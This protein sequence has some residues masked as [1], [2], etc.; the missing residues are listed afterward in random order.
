[1]PPQRRPSTCVR[2]NLFALDENAVMMLMMMMMM[3]MMMSLNVHAGWE[4]ATAQGGGE[5]RFA[6]AEA[7][8]A[9]RGR[10]L[11]SKQCEKLLV[12]EAKGV[13]G[14]CWEVV[15]VVWWWG[16]CLLLVPV[17]DVAYADGM[18]AAGGDADPGPTVHGVAALDQLWA[19]GR[20]C[21]GSG[22]WRR[23]GH[24]GASG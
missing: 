14:Y 12:S 18:V 3:M 21:G 17:D 5:E 24:A 2:K 8:D 23:R 16:S 13:V 11:R 1:M 10:P 4:H 19:C 22:A 15:V 9:V 20:A 7:A 6:G